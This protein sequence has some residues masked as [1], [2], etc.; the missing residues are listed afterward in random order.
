MRADDATPT[1]SLL[2][3]TG[4]DELARRRCSRKDFAAKSR[5]R[6]QKVSSGKRNYFLG[7]QVTTKIV[8]ERIVTP[9]RGKTHEKGSERTAMRGRSLA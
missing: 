9:K 1:A 2:G 4:A 6:T 8:A 3:T 5:R 7:A